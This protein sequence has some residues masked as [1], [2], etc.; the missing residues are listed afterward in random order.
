MQVAGCAGVRPAGERCSVQRGSLA[1]LRG[2][3]SVECSAAEMHTVTLLPLLV[4]LS[5]AAAEF[6]GSAIR[7]AASESPPP[8]LPPPKY[9][10][11]LTEHSP[12]PALSSAN[13]K[14]HGASPCP[15]TFNPSYV[16]VAGENK[17]GGIIVRMRSAHEVSLSRRSSDRAIISRGSFA[18]AGTD[19]CNATSGAMSWAPCDVQTGV[20]GDLNAS[21]LYPKSQGTEDPR[22]I[23]NKYL[24]APLDQ[25]L[26]LATQCI[27]GQ[28]IKRALLGG[29]GTT[30][31]ST[32]SPTARTAS[33]RKPTAAR[34]LAH[35]APRVPALWYTHARARARTHAR[36]HAHTHTHTH[37]QRERER[38]RGAIQ[39]GGSRCERDHHGRDRVGRHVSAHEDSP[40][41]K[42]HLR[43]HHR[44]VRH[45]RCRQPAPCRQRQR[46]EE[47]QTHDA[48]DKAAPNR[49]RDRHL[50]QPSWRPR[51]TGLKS[52]QSGLRKG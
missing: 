9:K 17:V 31:S 20:C 46:S 47:Q 41:A 25:S 44:A 23:F 5:P 11:V 13:A 30:I 7:P 38:E 26:Y 45:H 35:Q 3:E 29:A 1:P 2:V 15:T 37:T 52:P 28:S 27:C 43:E 24:P 42:N 16:E 34:P 33:S 12:T 8:P 51:S 22:I 18:R 48:L 50:A 14:G 32:T 36:T 21:Y 49:A 19:N 40:S 4:L 6:A 39:I 10:V